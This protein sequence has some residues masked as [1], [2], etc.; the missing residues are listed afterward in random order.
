MFSLNKSLFYS[1]FLFLFPI[2]LHY[3]LLSRTHCFVFSHNLD[4]NSLF[5]VSG[6]IK[7]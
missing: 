4:L 2:Y 7:G 5:A 1:D 6:L 3:S